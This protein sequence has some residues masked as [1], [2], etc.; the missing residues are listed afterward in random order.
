MISGQK[1]KWGL[2]FSSVYHFK[3]ALSLLRPRTRS[4]RRWMCTASCCTQPPFSCIFSLCILPSIYVMGRWGI[5]L[6]ICMEICT[7]QF[8]LFQKAINRITVHGIIS[9]SHFSSSIST[10]YHWQPSYIPFMANKTI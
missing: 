7:L 3:M 10:V 5:T 6:L 2:L 1:R 8:P 9:P 4:L